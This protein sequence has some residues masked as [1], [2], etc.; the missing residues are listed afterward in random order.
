MNNSAITLSNKI[1]ISLKQEYFKTSIIQNSSDYFPSF[2]KK[3]LEDYTKHY[4]EYLYDEIDLCVPFSNSKK[5]II[6]S[7]IIDLSESINKTIDLYYNGKFHEATTIFNASLERVFFNDIKMVKKIRKGS[8]FYRA[9]KDEDIHFS[10]EDLFHVPFQYRHIVS[11]NRYSLIGFPALY[12]A[13]ATY[14]CWEEFERY[15]L[16]DLWFSKIQNQEE[17]SVIEINH[18][19][20]FING[21]YN[22][23]TNK[24]ED[25]QLAYVLSYLVTYP[26]TL[27]C[28]IKA[29]NPHGNFKPEYIIPQLLLEYISTKQDI[30][31]IKFPSTKVDYSKLR[32]LHSYNYVFPVKSNNES[33][34]C[35]K[36]IEKFHVSEPTSLELEEIINNSSNVSVKSKTSV[37]PIGEIE[38]INGKKSIYRDTSF[39]KIEISLRNRRVYKL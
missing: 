14:T 36:L 26:L 4:Q 12:M 23:D 39:G 19:M 13:D 1:I 5:D 31:G 21:Y 35:D 20:E 27:A 16:R 28:T 8:S 33:G 24:N 29:K 7:K 17:L 38:L 2:I 18:F 22:N 25:E 11:T 30:D 32:G 15:R 3:A 10:K 9:R 6:I 34:F 37:H